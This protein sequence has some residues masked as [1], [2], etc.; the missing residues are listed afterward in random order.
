MQKPQILEDFEM[1]GKY[2]GKLQA[3]R[4]HSQRREQRGR[5]RASW[6]RRPWLL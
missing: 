6:R 5:R 3:Q 2:D 4:L 1:Y